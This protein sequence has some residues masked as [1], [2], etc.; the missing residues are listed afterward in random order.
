MKNKKNINYANTVFN[1]AY[2]R[3][4]IVGTTYVGEAMLVAV[5]AHT[6]AGNRE[7]LNGKVVRELMGDINL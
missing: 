7:G 3:D 1:R 4:N 2:I 6:Q 5:L